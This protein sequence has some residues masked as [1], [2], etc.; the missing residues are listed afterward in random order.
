LQS[1]PKNQRPPL[2]LIEVDLSEGS[3]RLAPFESEWPELEVIAEAGGSA[4]AWAL[5]ADAHR[6]GTDA[7]FVLAVGG[8]V[9]RGVP[10][11][12][13]V[14][15]SGRGAH[16]G[17]V[18][19]GA[20][21]GSFGRRLASVA[22][23]LVLRGRVSGPGGVLVLDSSGDVSVRRYEEVETL[24]DWLALLAER[25][26]DGAHLAVGP[27]AWRGVS[28]ANLAVGEDPPSFVG[29]GGLGGTLAGMGLWA[30]VVEAPEV[31]P[32]GDSLRLTSQLK[33]SPRL[34][35]RGAGGSLERAHEL[36]YQAA[37]ERT[38]E[39]ARAL[40]NVG[41]DA[42]VAL[43]GCSGCPT[44]C[45]WVFE[46]HDRV[47]QGG[48][49]NALDSLGASLGLR[50]PA[51]ALEL[52]AACDEV[53]VDAKE[54]G[55]ALEV[56]VRARREGKVTDGPRDGALED[57]TKE[58]RALGVDRSAGLSVGAL[59]LAER[60][61]LEA[62]TAR[63]EAARP[64]HGV[65]GVLALLVA[66]RG[67]EPMRTFAFLLEGGVPR[68]RAQALLHPLTVTARG[69][70]PADQ[71]EKG[72]LV[73]WHENFV[74][75]VDATGFCAF[76]A[77]GVIADG[78]MDLGALAA[79]LLELQEESA[80]AES[81][82]SVGASVTLLALEVTGGASS[83]EL[84]ARGMGESWDEYRSLRG[85]DEE[86]RVLPEVAEMLGSAGVLRYEEAARVEDER[87]HPRDA[88]A[89]E[90]CLKVSA[91]G[92]LGRALGG[93]VELSLR[94]PASLAEALEVLTEDRRGVRELLF[95]GGVPIA[96]GWRDGE[97]VDLD[98]LLEDG[99][100]IDLVLAVGGG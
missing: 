47:R 11:A 89:T 73:W 97:R 43:R 2:H 93:A 92:E 13:R 16:T 28:Y 35:E 100:H 62:Q 8:A 96:S 26:P 12:A 72:R 15:V 56:W 95:V 58:V 44:P 75:G 99:D 70:D 4:L 67:A 65:G 52:L 55:A 91:G 22:D 53:G 39:G 23:A 60:F 63:G 49:F 80:A 46:T 38:V 87:S 45:G 88:K 77:A 86:G 29:R 18:A 32:G 1:P 59:G 25:H 69:L 6:S 66:G 90:G 36:R 7:P 9:K 37:D 85:L 34:R 98:D 54:A 82:L 71:A 78:V 19:E 41:A 57:L 5:Q 33:R 10:T 76:S 51:D 3:D 24:S 81:L 84:R 20:V 27:A 17:R 14:S 21:G 64:R 68:E 74:A 40:A 94:L 61:A 79:Q 30:V 48:R 31:A 50:D 42:G 83:A